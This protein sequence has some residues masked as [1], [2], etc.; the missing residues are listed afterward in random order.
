MSNLSPIQA[1]KKIADNPYPINMFTPLTKI[2]WNHIR[3]ALAKNGISLDRLSADIA[4]QIRKNDIAIAT[5]ALAS[6]NKSNEE[7]EKR[8]V[9]LRQKAIT[10]FEL[11]KGYTSEQR[12]NGGWGVNTFNTMEEMAGYVLELT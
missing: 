9:E 4:R 1:L 10:V 5:E 3:S 6:Y 11:T 7:A 12:Q 2:E 8:K